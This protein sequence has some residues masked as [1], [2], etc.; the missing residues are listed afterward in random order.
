MSLITDNT[1]FIKRG[2]SLLSIPHYLGTQ[3]K[4]ALWTLL[5]FHLTAK[6]EIQIVDLEKKN[7]IITVSYPH[8]Q[9]DGCRITANDST[10]APILYLYQEAML[11]RWGG[12][13]VPD[14][15]GGEKQLHQLFATKLCGWLDCRHR[16]PLWKKGPKHKTYWVKQRRPRL[17]K[18]VAH[19]A[20]NINFQG[21]IDRGVFCIH[22]SA[23]CVG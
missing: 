2:E 1:V 12:L 17:G 22:L 20:A 13:T 10:C 7:P 9:D 4:T 5:A 6:P 14:G 16:H 8:K 11:Q 23:G 18:H 21:E 3:W 19:S 15:L